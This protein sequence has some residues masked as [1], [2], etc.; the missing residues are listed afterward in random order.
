MLVAQVNSDGQKQ[1]VHNDHEGSNTLITDSS[2]N[3]VENTFYSPFGEI[4]EG[5]KYSRYG[6]EGKEYDSQVEDLDFKF[7]KYNPKQPPIFNQPDTLI[8]NVYD[9]QSLNRYSFERNNP[10]KNNDPSGHIFGIDDFIIGLVVIGFAIYSGYV[11]ANQLSTIE[12]AE[13]G[14]STTDTSLAFLNIG[15]I[16]FPNQ[17]AGQLL[18]KFFGKRAYKG[19]FD[20][21]IENLKSEEISPN[22]ETKEDL[23]CKII[24]CDLK[25]ELDTKHDEGDK[26]SDS[27]STATPSSQADSSKAISQSSQQN[28]YQASEGYLSGVGYITSE[29]RVYPTSNPYYV[30]GTGNSAWGGSSSNVVQDPS[31]GKWVVAE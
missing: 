13:G 16:V 3:V 10:Y 1:A 28:L 14:L 2:G 22:V 26:Q 8:Q 6:Y 25:Y 15:L 20:K 4:L 23:R 12:K 21:R 11:L 31:T 7:R 17:G 29:G 5:G 9:P 19:Y 18:T 30:P 27:P 24:K